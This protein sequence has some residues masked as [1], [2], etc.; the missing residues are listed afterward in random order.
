MNMFNKKYPL[1]FAPVTILLM[2]IVF[3]GKIS[4]QSDSVSHMARTFL[5]IA[6]PVLQNPDSASVKYN[7]GNSTKRTLAAPANDNFAS[8]TALAITIGAGGFTANQSCKGGSLEAGESTDCQ[9][10]NSSTW[11]GAGL[12]ST[13]PN[14]TVW[15][16]F[17]PT[18]AS[19]TGP[20]YI[21]LL[22]KTDE[23]KSAA[24]LGYGSSPTFYY[25][26]MSVWNTST[27]PTGSC[28]AMQ[29]MDNEDI[30]EN[31]WYNR[32]QLNAAGTS[33]MQ[34][35]ETEYTAIV[36]NLTIGT[37]YYI[38]VGFADNTFADA[39][40]IAVS[41]IAQP[42]AT[43]TNP[44][45]IT[46]SGQANAAGGCTALTCPLVPDEC[47]LTGCYIPMY[48]GVSNCSHYYWNG[49]AWVIDQSTCEACPAGTD[50]VSS[51]NSYCYPCASAVTTSCNGVQ[52]V[53]AAYPNSEYP[54]YNATIPGGSGWTYQNAS[55]GSA[56]GG[57]V[58]PGY[59][60]EYCYDFT[61]PPSGVSSA[62][63]ASF[64]TYYP[65]QVAINLGA[66]GGLE[67]ELWLEWELYNSTCTS[68]LAC[69]TIANFTLAGVQ[70]GA[71]YVLCVHQQMGAGSYIGNNTAGF[72]PFVDFPDCNPG[73]CLPLP[74]SLS[75][76]QVE[77]QQS[78][79]SVIVYWSTSS[80]TNNKLFTVEKSLDGDN[81][82]E[83]ST[84]P[85]AG[86]T[87][88]LLYYNIADEKPWP[89]LSYYR[90]KQTDFDGNSTYSE[91]A[92]VNIPTDYTA[93]IYPNPVVGQTLNLHYTSASPEP[94]S[95]NVTDIAGHSV[96]SF[97]L[98][99]IKPGT[100]NLNLELPTSMASGMYFVKVSNSQKTFLLKFV[101]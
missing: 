70:C 54:A 76:F 77:Y 32:A 34:P 19:G 45:P 79:G 39:F 13:A 51:G 94:I 100:N 21:T 47:P 63:K 8:A 57:V 52:F 99:T 69:G 66:G 25:H 27:L 64:Q 101:K 7:I 73:T 24:I 55:G 41:T 29:C 82:Q 31:Y 85:G 28:M 46:A 6:P 59:C 44:L 14:T 11:T 43:I 74:I 65:D 86:T 38:Q 35:A 91:V 22:E 36:N 40:Q 30:G 50:A 16:S 1:Y 18:V 71:N 67:F 4:A 90:L 95:V 12:Y 72:Y 23:T 60:L 2:V 98:N 83:V 3:N 89:G 87:S 96:A 80:Q 97:A 81:W 92:T 49:S 9:G 26:G 78:S 84:I 15:Y 61:I 88:E 17:T 37:T 56:I 48:F 5:N 93:T 75:S 68:P 53:S 62:A 33:L 42:G 58:P 10:F 20:L